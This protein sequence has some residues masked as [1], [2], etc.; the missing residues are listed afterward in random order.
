M[1]SRQAKE[2]LRLY[3]PGTLDALDPQIALA[4]QEVQR[5]PALAEWFNQQ[6]GV[7]IA[8]RSKLKQIE[9]PPDLKR[10]ILLGNL[11]RRRIISF[12][13]PAP[14]LAAAAA[15]AL[16]ATVLWTVFAP[17][18]DV[19]FSSYRERVSGDALRG[20]QMTKVSTNL[21]E[22]QAF[23]D[24]K[25]WPADYVLPRSL[26]QLVPEGCANLEWHNKKYSM[27]CFDAGK[28]KDGKT[29]ELYLLVAPRAEL[30]DVPVSDK[31]QFVR[32]HDQGI[33]TASW[34]AG[35]NVYL[36]FGKGEPDL[37][38]YFD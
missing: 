35:K 21:E 4:L 14:L 24:E 38:Q 8:L 17:K 19:R 27:L 25:K 12:P 30:Q 26:Q 18:V 6:C 23:L 28:N 36:L 37:A 7:C 22:I 2:I 31:P 5:D 32:V 33:L 34:A 1:D 13:R 15:V 16:L 11:G 3:R 29:K 20:Y 10:K 9:V